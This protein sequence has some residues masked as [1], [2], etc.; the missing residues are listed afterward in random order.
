MISCNSWLFML[1][2]NYWMSRNQTFPYWKKTRSRRERYK[3]LERTQ[4]AQ[5]GLGSS[6]ICMRLAHKLFYLWNSSHVWFVQLREI[7][8]L[9]KC[10]FCFFFAQLL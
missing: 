3:G 4:V 7:K 8:R 9:A 5:T 6:H 2:I 1:S 10:C